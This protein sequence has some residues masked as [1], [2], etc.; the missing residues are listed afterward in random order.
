MVKYSKAIGATLGAVSLW[1]AAFGVQSVGGFDL[2]HLFD[3]L[4]TF[5]GSGIGAYVAPPNT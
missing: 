2:G 1:L 4:A 5:V 3:L